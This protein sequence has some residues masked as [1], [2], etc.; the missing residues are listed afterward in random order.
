MPSESSTAN[1]AG[2]GDALRWR[3]NGK[4]LGRGEQLAWPPWPGRHVL[5][6]TDAQGTVLDEVRIEVRGA[7]VRAAP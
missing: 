5:Q 1:A 7:G 4:A 2:A 6:L 3:L